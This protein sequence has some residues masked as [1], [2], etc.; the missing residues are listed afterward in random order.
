[1]FTDLRIHPPL[2]QVFTHD[3]LRLYQYVK[4]YIYALKKSEEDI[5]Q[6]VY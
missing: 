1:M 5:N 4:R 6:T 3:N 2:K